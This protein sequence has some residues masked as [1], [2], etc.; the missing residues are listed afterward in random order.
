VTLST[1][2]VLFSG[3]SK[4]NYIRQQQLALEASRLTSADAFQ[5]LSLQIAQA[6]LQVLLAIETSRTSHES[7]RLAQTQRDIIHKLFQAGRVPEGNV[8][9][10]DAQIARTELAMTEADNAVTLANL[11]LRI[12]LELPQEQAFSVDTGIGTPQP[13][14]PE[15]YE[16]IIGQAMNTQPMIRA[17][18]YNLSSSEKAVAVARGGYYP[19]VS[20]FAGL[21]SNYSNAREQ[22]DVQIGPP[23]TIGEVIG[24]GAPVISSQPSFNLLTS[25]YPLGSQLDDN[26]NQAVGVSVRI[27]IFNG[28][29]ARTQVE[30]AKLQNLQAQY[31]L[32]QQRSN[33]RNAVQQAHANT[34]AAWS[35]YE[36]SDKS[37]KAARLAFDY[38]QKRHA[39]GMVSPYDFNAAQ[40]SLFQAEIDFISSKYQYHFMRLILDYYEGKPLRINE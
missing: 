26:F 5:Q 35:R 34:I 21:Y 11:N 31:N 30:Q 17:A 4:V 3:F 22:F 6:Y 36:A 10:A 33:L 7:V 39:E 23:D 37:L 14:A 2:L 12:L 13:S 15:S 28:L 25:P 24:S 18:E 19:T 27:P 8:M 16:A 38:T 1:G 40:N 20:L 29:Q 9:E 32:Q